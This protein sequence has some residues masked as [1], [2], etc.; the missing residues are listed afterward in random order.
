MES[1][2]NMNANEV[3]VALR[4]LERHREAMMK[5]Y[6]KNKDKR[7]AYAKSYYNKKKAEKKVE[8]VK[9]AST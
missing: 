9:E 7:L 6:H 2:V 4:L 1:T 5:S 3:E 8:E